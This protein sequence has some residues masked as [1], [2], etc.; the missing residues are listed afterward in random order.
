M[1]QPAKAEDDVMT[2][3]GVSVE[4]LDRLAD[5]VHE[6]KSGVESLGKRLDANA[7]GFRKDIRHLD[8][9]LDS[10]LGEVRGDI[11]HL[12]AKLDSNIGEVK[13]DIK[14]LDQIRRQTR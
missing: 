1:T 12:D 13:G 7:E 2:G 4:R 8:A 11:R 10:N 5:D 9:K 6:I 14:R 3:E